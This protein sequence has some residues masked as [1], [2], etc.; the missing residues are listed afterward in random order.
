VGSVLL[1][2]A[3]TLLVACGGRGPAGDPGGVPPPGM[4]PREAEPARA[5]P[6][7]SPAGALTGD[8]SPLFRRGLRLLG[9]GRF[10]AA[11]STLREVVARC[12]RRDEAERAVLAL[13]SLHLD[14]RNPA[15]QPDSAALMAARYLTAADV[16]PLGRRLAEGM[17]IQA[18][19]RGADPGVRPGDESRGAPPCPASRTVDAPALPTLESRRYSDLLQEA[20]SRLD[21]LAAVH[22]EALREVAEL[23]AELAR[24]RRLLQEPDTLVVGPGRRPSAGDL[25]PAGRGGEPATHPACCR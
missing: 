13:A 9:E 20:S 7:A 25:P 1:G 15:A 12:A 21:S 22:R 23:E 8:D 2:A 4:V 19:D 3:L 10:A 17:W 6:A 14:A 16:P 5:R 24:I 11:D 18:L